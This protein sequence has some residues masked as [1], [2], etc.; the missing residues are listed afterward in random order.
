[1]QVRFYCDRNREEVGFLANFTA[2]E[3]KTSCLI[4]FDKFHGFEEQHKYITSMLCMI[5]KYKR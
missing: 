4:V 2:G 1:M 5:M 3:N